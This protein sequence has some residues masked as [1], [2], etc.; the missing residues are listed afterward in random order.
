MASVFITR[1]KTR[2]GPRHVVRY[3]LGGR[4]YPIVHGGS[5]KKL[6]EAQ[7]RQRLIG[8]ELAAGRNPQQLLDAMLTP[9]EP[10]RVDVLRDLGPRYLTSRVDLDAKT[11]KAHRSAL[12]RVYAWAG[13]RDP[14]T[15]TFN[16]CQLFVGTLIEGDADH[17]P[18]RASTARK[19]FNVLKLL[20][21]F[22][23]VEPNA[24]RDS[25][26]KLP[27]VRAQEPNWR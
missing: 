7:E 5:F 22:A 18:L 14:H 17:K 25:R 6:R 23:G 9:P 15:L 27:T 12:E 8:G 19:Y 4:T 11:E 26:V 10:V 1:R 24:A 3:R 20:L 16:D 21:D 13:G 2:S